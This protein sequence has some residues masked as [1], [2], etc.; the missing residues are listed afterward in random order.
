MGFIVTVDDDTELWL[1]FK[2]IFG[3]CFGIDRWGLFAYG[4]EVVL[5]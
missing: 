3:G 1:V 5:V 2:A 4:H